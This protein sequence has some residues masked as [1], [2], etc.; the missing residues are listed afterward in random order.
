MSNKEVI[1]GATHDRPCFYSFQDNSTGL[2]W[3]IPFTSQLSKFQSIYDKKMSKYGKCDTIVFGDVLGY[4]KAFLIQNMCPIIPKYIKNQYIENL[5][6]KPVRLN[7]KL[8]KELT[9]KAKKVLMLCRKGN[10]LIF[11]DIFK[12][13]NELLSQLPL[14]D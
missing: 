12:I 13:E 5:S 2:F 14:G 6:C 7:G 8:E 1:G 4:K 9:S 3:I 11:P 10:K